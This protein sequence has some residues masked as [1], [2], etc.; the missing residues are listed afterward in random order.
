MPVK[1]KIHDG[2]SLIETMLWNG[3][4]YAFFDEHMLR[5][6]LS[7]SAFGFDDVSIRIAKDLKDPSIAPIIYDEKLIIKIILHRKGSFDIFGRNLVPFP[8]NAKIILSKQLVDSQNSFLYHKTTSRELYDAEFHKY[9][10]QGDYIEVI[11]ENEDGYI[12][13][14]S[15]TNIFIEKDGQLFTPAISCGLLPGIMRQ[16]IL[17]KNGNIQESFITKGELLSADKIFICNSVRGII[18]VKFCAECC[19]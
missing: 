13:E 17:N 5:L 16:D 18:Q 8:E 11:F 15:R 12:T 1:S 9:C 2:F 10:I 7:A 19:I 4:R 3:N 6:D 14:G